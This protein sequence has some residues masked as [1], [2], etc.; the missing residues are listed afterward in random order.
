M[1]R[2]QQIP[3]IGILK[4]Q[5]LKFVAG[6][7]DMATASALILCARP[8]PKAIVGAIICDNGAAL[9]RGLAGEYNGEIVEEAV[10]GSSRLPGEQ[11]DSFVIWIS[12][13]KKCGLN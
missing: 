10:C 3:C 6:H 9:H 5:L 2:M 4:Q 11:D 1:L 13:S 7:R 8:N 12:M